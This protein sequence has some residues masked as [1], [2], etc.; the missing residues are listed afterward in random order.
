MNYEINF[1]LILLLIINQKKLISLTHRRNVSIIMMKKTFNCIDYC[2]F[3]KKKLQI[4]KTFGLFFTLKCYVICIS[5]KHNVNQSFNVKNEI[6][7]FENDICELIKLL[8]KKQ[9]IINNNKRYVFHYIALI[10]ATE[11]IAFNKNFNFML[12]FIKI[13]QIKNFW[14]I[15]KRQKLK[16]S[17]QHRCERSI[18]SA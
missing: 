13:L 9:S 1:F 14:I 18:A 16:K 6:L 3:C 4:I 12:N 5:I 2:Q 17:T 10:I 8:K 15:K 7:K 11:K